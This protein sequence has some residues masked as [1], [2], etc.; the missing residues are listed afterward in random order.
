[1]TH[2]LKRRLNKPLFLFDGGIHAREWLAIA[3]VTTLIDKV[4]SIFFV[5]FINYQILL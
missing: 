2:N 1:M 3:T 5:F 4:K